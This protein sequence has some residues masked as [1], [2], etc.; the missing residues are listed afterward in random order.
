MR[1]LG[2]VSFGFSVDGIT[3]SYVG[4][5]CRKREGIGGGGGGPGG[6]PGGIK[7]SL[8]LLGCVCVLVFS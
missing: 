1:G 7:P 6:T 8:I 2:C 4:F 5:S 3:G